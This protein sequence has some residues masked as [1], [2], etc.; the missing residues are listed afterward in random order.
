METLY[1]PFKLNVRNTA[2]RVRNESSHLGVSLSGMVRMWSFWI[3]SIVPIINVVSLARA[4]LNGR[5]LVRKHISI[6][7]MYTSSA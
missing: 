6:H 5:K 7:T 3:S 1:N 2:T 4:R